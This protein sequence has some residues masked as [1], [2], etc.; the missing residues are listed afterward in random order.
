MVSKFNGEPKVVSIRPAIS[1][2][3]EAITRLE[4]VAI[5]S[6]GASREALEQQW[7]L[8]AVTLD[9]AA[10][11][12]VAEVET[13]PVGYIT[14]VVVNEG[15]WIR[16]YVCDLYVEDRYR[17]KRAA[18][19]MMDEMILKMREFGARVFFTNSIRNGAAFLKLSEKGNFVK[20]SAR[21]FYNL[22]MSE[23]NIGLEGAK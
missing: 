21:E 19:H 12:L 16:G 4:R 8:S 15:S 1:A 11:V 6:G 2:D 9:V 13:V 20:L 14:G 5:A 17:R 22:V 7:L 10:I 18:V 3:R 23:Q